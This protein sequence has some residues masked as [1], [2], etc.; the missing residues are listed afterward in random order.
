MT[1]ETVIDTAT[2]E[3]VQ[4]APADEV[5]I[6]PTIVTD[7]SKKKP[8]RAAANDAEVPP[9]VAEAQEIFAGNPGVAAVLTDQG[10]LNR[11][12]TFNDVLSP[13]IAGAFVAE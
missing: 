6:D 8:K 5:P 4:E 2:P 7:A 11:D 13:S 1:D 10:Y 9:T 3:P 12:G